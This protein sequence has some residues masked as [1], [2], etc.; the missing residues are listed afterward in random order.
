MICFLPLKSCLP[1]VQVL[2]PTKDQSDRFRCRSKISSG[3]GGPPVRCNNPIISAC[4]NQNH[5][6]GL[7]QK[8]YNKTQ[9]LAI[10]ASS[11]HIS[12]L[13]LQLSSMAYLVNC[14]KSVSFLFANFA[15]WE[16]VG[17]R[18]LSSNAKVAVKLHFSINSILQISSCIDG[19]KTQQKFSD[20][21]TF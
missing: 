7:C 14:H 2:W 13:K 18:L 1:F 9:V 20:E 5:Q 19:N 6:E 4:Q 11:S 3:V 15:I 10:F 16:L 21:S 12:L 8:C 17:S